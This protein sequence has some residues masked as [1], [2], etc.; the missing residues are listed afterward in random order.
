MKLSDLIIDYR[1]RMNIYQREFSRQRAIAETYISFIE[2]GKNPR[3]GKPMVPTLEQYKKIA[4]GMGI[5]VQRLF[6]LLD[7]DAPVDMGSSSDGF[8]IGSS[9]SD[10]V[11]QTEEARILAKGIDQLPKEQ[12]EQAL[13][14]VRAMFEKYAKFFEKENADDT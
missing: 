2:K 5:S 1:K 3:T 6:E 12:R 8:F 11:P 7:K 9:F 13:S 14:V 4:T 10:G